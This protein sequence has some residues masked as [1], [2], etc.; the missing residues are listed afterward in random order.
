YSFKEAFRQNPWCWHDRLR[1]LSLSQTDLV[2]PLH[3]KGIV[4]IP[5]NLSSRVE[6]ERQSP[7]RDRSAVIP[8]ETRLEF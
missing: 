4:E 3:L 2:A 5:G 8:E 1:H 7:I 6:N